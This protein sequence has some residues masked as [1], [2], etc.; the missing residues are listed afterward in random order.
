MSIC[1]IVGIVD[2]LI[3][4]YWHVQAYTAPMIYL[5]TTTFARHMLPRLLRYIQ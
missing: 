3:K 2:W 5:S 1:F 4:I